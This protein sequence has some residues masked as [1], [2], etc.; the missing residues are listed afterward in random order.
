MIELWS[1]VQL[2]RKP[3]LCGQNLWTV[4]LEQ[5]QYD[6]GKDPTILFENLGSSE[7]I[8]RL[9]EENAFIISKNED[10]EAFN[11]RSTRL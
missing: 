4:V 5:V 8:E 10:S 9:R 2:V 3:S 11:A 7:Y 6:P 1:L